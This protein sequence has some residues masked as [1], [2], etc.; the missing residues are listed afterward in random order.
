MSREMVQKH[1]NVF[2]YFGHK[3]QIAKRVIVFE[4][5]SVESG[6]L[7]KRSDNSNLIHN[8]K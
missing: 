8:P 1:H 3:R 6:P 5:I 7:K 4:V 2:K